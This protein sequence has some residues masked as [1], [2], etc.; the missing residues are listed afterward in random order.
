M[1]RPDPCW[2]LSPPG[3]GYEPLPK[4][5]PLWVI[6]CGYRLCRERFHTLAGDQ[7]PGDDWRLIEPETVRP[8]LPEVPR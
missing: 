5:P 4:A 2:L 6:E 8:V 7:N 3:S 1:S